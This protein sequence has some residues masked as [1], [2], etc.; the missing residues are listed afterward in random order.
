MISFGHNLRSHVSGSPTEGV[1]RV[2]RYRLQTE[3]KINQFQLFISVE[4]NILGLDISVNNISFMKVF[5]SF[6]DDF[7][8][9]FRL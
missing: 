1:N 7:E 6:S 3:P 4:Q 5:D 2:G 9:L 8:K